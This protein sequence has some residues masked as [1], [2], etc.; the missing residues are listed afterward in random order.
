MSSPKYSVIVPTRMRA[1][2]LAA[3]LRAFDDVAYDD[4][5]VIVG[6]NCS[7]PETQQLVLDQPSPKIKYYRSDQP[8]AMSNNFELAL[9]HASGQWIT[10]IGDDDAVLPN[11]FSWLDHVIGQTNTRLVGWDSAYYVWP[12]RAMPFCSDYLKIPLAR[13]GRI[14]NSREMLKAVFASPMHYMNDTTEPAPTPRL[15]GCYHGAVH[16]SIFEQLQR[17]GGRAFAGK[18]PDV[19]LSMA[20]VYLAQQYIYLDFPLTVYGHSCHSNGGHQLRNLLPQ[21]DFFPMCAADQLPTHP[22]VGS[23]F[24]LPVTTFID[25]LLLVKQRLFP[26]DQELKME[27]TDL[28]KHALSTFVPNRQ[29]DWP[30]LQQS[31]R[32]T[33]KDEPVLRDWV[34]QLFAGIP[35]PTPIPRGTP[36]YPKGAGPLGRYLHLDASRFGVED[37]CGAA[38]LV[39]KIVQPLPPRR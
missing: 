9:Q 16:R 24:V 3:C 39:D 6:D 31:I 30:T 15:P 17:T 28:I 38:R 36:G 11:M 22:W 1:R 8:L 21:P 29:E 26:D 14:V 20:A 10:Y 34:E 7:S 4:Y 18:Y 33:V 5:E 27:R 13:E 37:V 23:I 19:Y 12:T 25:S 32:A 35:A 2:T